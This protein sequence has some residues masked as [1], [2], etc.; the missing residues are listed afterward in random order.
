MAALVFCEGLSLVERGL[1]VADFSDRLISVPG[2]LELCDTLKARPGL[3]A[4]SALASL[5]VTRCSLVRDFASTP[6]RARNCQGYL[7]ASHAPDLLQK[8]TN[9]CAKI[10]AMRSCIRFGIA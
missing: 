4:L 3:A 7:I 1:S 2:S 8:L 5:S 9:K 6:R 10:A